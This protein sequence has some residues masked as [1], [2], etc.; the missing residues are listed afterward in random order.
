MSQCLDDELRQALKLVPE[1]VRA[2]I[3]SRMRPI[4]RLDRR[5]ALLRQLAASEFYS[6]IDERHRPRRIAADL[7]REASLQTVPSDE[8]RAALREV[9]RLNNDAPV[10]RRQ[11]LNILSGD[12]TPSRMSASQAMTRPD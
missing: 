1:P 9:L 5:D 8:R 12:R 2:V 6:D 4:S 3:L 11:L 10:S 7:A